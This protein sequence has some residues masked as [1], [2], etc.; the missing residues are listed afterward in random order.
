LLRT[1]VLSAFAGVVIASGW[2]RL[3]RPRDDGLRVVGLVALGIAPALAP[4]A[5]ARAI[6]AVVALVAALSVAFFVPLR[7]LAPDGWHFIGRAASRFADGFA[8]F[9][10]FRLPIDPG[11]HVHMHMVLLFAAFSFTLVVA[12]AVAARRPVLAVSCFLVGAGWPAT[13]LAG[14]H[15]VARGVVILVGALALLAGLSERAGRFAAPAA[16]AVALGAIALSTSPAVAKPAFL[17]W[18]HWNPYAHPARPLSVSFVWNGRYS[19]IRFPR[20]VTR[21]LTIRAPQTIGTY[22]RATILDT[23]VHDRWVE[24]FWR[25]TPLERHAL[26]PPAAQKPANAVQQEVTVDALGDDHLVAASQP[27]GFNV[28]EPEADVGQGVAIALGGLQRGERYIAWSYVPKPSV[29]ALVRSQ[30]SYPRAL[31]RRGRELEVTP[32]VEALPFG[33][34]GRTAALERRLVGPMA[35]YRQLFARALSVVGRTQSP[36]AATLALEQWFRTTGGFTYSLQPPPTPGL[37]PLVGFVLR[38]QTGYCQHF[39]GAMALMA[40]MLG[41]PA[42]VAAGFV[43][44]HF[45]NGEWQVTDRDAHTWVEVWFRGYGWLPFDPTPGRGRLAAPYSAASPSF[46]VS[47]ESKLLSTV[48]RGGEVFGTTHV[49]EDRTPHRGRNLHSQADVGVRGLGG[50][51]QASHGHSL[52]RFLAL[53]ALGAIAAILVAKTARRKLRYVTRDPRRIAA[54][55]AHEL[56]DFLADQRLPVRR[57]A[58]YGDLRDAVSEHLAV[59]AQSFTDALDAARFGPP[60]GA[61]AAARRAKSELADLKRRLRRQVFLLDRARGAVS[62]RSLGLG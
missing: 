17:D 18:Q 44:G 15:E 28:S 1:V 31:T 6:A 56:A 25:E 49:V 26:V 39:A 20:K 16:G 51:A 13:L 52:G 46:D 10:S 57:G 22:W 53:L 11:L 14:G 27:V 21:L 61:G 40:R 59:D 8:D 3:E 32:G 12:L 5:W 41:I 43:S 24:H 60:S 7:V 30:A 45:V 23:Y 50:A 54:A 58:T 47:R 33:T 2:L 29:E 4:R 38:T 19:G 9:Y 35:P 62:L 36:Y 42:R 55:C 34:P 48:V 37:P